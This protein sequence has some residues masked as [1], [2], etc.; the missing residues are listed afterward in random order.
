MKP[1]VGTLSSFTWLTRGTYASV[2]KTIETYRN[3]GR[4]ISTNLFDT[5]SSTK[6]DEQL[7]EDDDKEISL[8]AKMAAARSGFHPKVCQRILDEFEKIKIE[9]EK[10][11]ASS[12][13]KNKTIT[14]SFSN[15]Q[16]DVLVDSSKLKTI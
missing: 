1:A 8:A 2:K 11:M 10:K 7:Q 15:T 16:V 6:S 13:K 5:G 14:S 4:H 3:E 12:K 9:Q